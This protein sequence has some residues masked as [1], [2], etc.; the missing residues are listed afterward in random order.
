MVLKDVV[1]SA[2]AAGA[3]AG[4]AAEP[5][6]GGTAASGGAP[7]KTFQ[8]RAK[9]GA[10]RAR[11]WGLRPRLCGVPGGGPL[12]EQQRRLCGLRA[13]GAHHRST[14][15]TPSPPRPNPTCLQAPAAAALASGPSS[16]PAPRTEP[17][18][19]P[20]PA[21]GARAR[22]APGRGSLGSRGA[23]TP[24]SRGGSPGAASG[25]ASSDTSGDELDE[26]DEDYASSAASSSGGSGSESDGE[27]AAAAPPSAWRA[28]RRGRSSLLPGAALP[29]GATWRQ[30]APGT[31]LLQRWRGKG[32]S[33]AK[34]AA[35][36]EYLAQMA[37]HFAEVHGGLGWD[38]VGGGGGGGG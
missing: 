27:A 5:A 6:A 20:A 30:E 32:L 15:P 31:R 36:E 33:K 13:W 4:K 7:L 23:A 34:R 21:G 19:E 16:E 10:A 37:A 28:P 8:R 35:L 22:T 26:D 18:P 25:S 11:G 3:G 38:S 17:A 29:G 9:V 2:G 12:R 24:T 1:N 14:L